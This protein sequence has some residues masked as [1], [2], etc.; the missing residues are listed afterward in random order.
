MNE[1]KVL[2]IED[3]ADIRDLVC[4]EFQSLGWKVMDVENGEIA[5]PLLKGI[6]FDVVVSD[7]RMPGGGGVEMI[8]KWAHLH[9]PRPVVVFMSGHCDYTEEQ[10]KDMGAGAFINKPF[11]RE[12]LHWAIIQALEAGVHQQRAK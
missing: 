10:L 3:D 6:A 9:E 8:Q 4:R 12:E 5:M 11:T 2:I 1:K 7:I